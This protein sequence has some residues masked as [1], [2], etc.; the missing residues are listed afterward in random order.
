MVTKT[1]KEQLDFLD[2]IISKSTRPIQILF[3]IIFFLF[4]IAISILISPEF[5]EK[6]I[7]LMIIVGGIFILGVLTWKLMSK[8]PEYEY[9]ELESNFE[10]DDEIQ[11]FSESKVAFIEIKSSEA[12][13]TKFPI[14]VY[15]THAGWSVKIKTSW[16]RRGCNYKI[17]IE[18]EDK[19]I[20]ISKPIQIPA[21]STKLELKKEK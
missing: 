7:I 14:S 12:P 16:L 10:F 17:T 5:S 3:A 21:F 4:I 1:L 11:L 6:G 8:Y 15:S 18:D 13:D 2:K 9:Y 20:W 19:N